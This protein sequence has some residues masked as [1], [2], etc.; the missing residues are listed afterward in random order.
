MSEV[1]IIQPNKGAKNPL[2]IFCHVQ[3]ASSFYYISASKFL[4]ETT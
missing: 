3:A 2:I 1:I 4:V